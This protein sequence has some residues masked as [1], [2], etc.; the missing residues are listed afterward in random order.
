MEKIRMSITDVQQLSEKI[1]QNLERVIIGKRQVLE[2]TL[3][4]LLSQGHILIE[5]VPGVG[6]PC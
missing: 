1:L 3:I 4:G 6:K 5:D 2:L